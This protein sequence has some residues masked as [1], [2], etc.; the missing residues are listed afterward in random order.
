LVNGSNNAARAEDELRLPSA[1]V[2]SVGGPVTSGEFWAF[3][4]NLYGMPK[5]SSACLA[6][7]DRE[8][9]DVNLLLFAAWLGALGHRLTAPGLRHARVLTEEWQRDV[10]T[11]LRTV[12]LGLKGRAL[13]TPDHLTHAVKAAELAAE[14][15]EQMILEASVP[16]GASPDMEAAGRE[17]A[18][19]NLRMVVSSDMHRLSDHQER[20]LAV[21]DRALAKLLA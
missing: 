5:V 6:L 3:S 8:G 19:N 9:L 12:R 15:V 21:F 20:D 2:D 16:R 1:D 14:Q 4:L 7:H 13:P 17:L 10:V 18:M 11:S